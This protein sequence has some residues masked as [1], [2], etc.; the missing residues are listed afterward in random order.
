M[1]SAEV[2]GGSSGAGAETVGG[3]AGDLSTQWSRIG[4][5]ELGGSGDDSSGVC[6]WRGASCADLIGDPSEG[7]CGGKGGSNGGCMIHVDH[8]RGRMP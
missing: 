5:N 4:D 7:D 1:G 6:A 8:N 2:S 3:S